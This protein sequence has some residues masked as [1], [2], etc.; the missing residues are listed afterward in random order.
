MLDIMNI[1]YNEFCESLSHFNPLE[2]LPGADKVNKAFER[3]KHHF[4]AWTHSFEGKNVRVIIAKSICSSVVLG[5]FCY[6]LCGAFAMAI[7]VALPLAFYATAKCDRSWINTENIGTQLKILAIAQ[8]SCFFIKIRILTWI[9]NLFDYSKVDP[10]DIP[11]QKD[12]QEVVQA[13]VKQDKIGTLYQSWCLKGPLMEEILF[14]GFLMD[15]LHYAQ[16]KWSPGA[17]DSTSAKVVR[18]G[19]QAIAFGAAHYRP[20]Q[21]LSNYVIV[22][23]TAISGVCYGYLREKTS[24]VVLPYLAHM[25]HNFIALSAML[26][27]LS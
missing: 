18:V 26:A 3:G 21:K 1:K 27:T 20:S 10:S 8:L 24:N 22:A 15:V 17:V 13:Y 11:G 25:I 6:A 19:L 23:G 5:L 12:H 16:R 7:G 14:R 4:F 2:Q 9:A